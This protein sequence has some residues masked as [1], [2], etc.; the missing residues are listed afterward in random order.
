MATSLVKIK[1]LL[2]DPDNDD[3][4]LLE[5]GG[6]AVDMRDAVVILPELCAVFDAAIR[7]TVEDTAA[8]QAA[9]N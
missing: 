3:S 1:L 8:E 5:V 7:Q 4:L 9:M 6:I 2:L